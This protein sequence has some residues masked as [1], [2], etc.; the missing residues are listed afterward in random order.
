MTFRLLSVSLSTSFIYQ[1]A[2]A[3]E[4]LASYS[5]SGRL[6]HAQGHEG[7]LENRS[8]ARV[9]RQVWAD[10]CS[11]W[12]SQ[13][14]EH[15]GKRSVGFV[16]QFVL[17]SSDL[18]GMVGGLVEYA[19]GVPQDVREPLPSAAFAPFHRAPVASDEASRMRF[20]SSGLRPTSVHSWQDRRAGRQRRVPVICN[21]L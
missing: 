4:D 10:G 5:E 11:V 8:V 19:L 2:I 12:H 7:R 14:D 21:P 9:P 6:R 18:D 17:R 16:R 1:V 13:L 20:Q 15:R 3:C